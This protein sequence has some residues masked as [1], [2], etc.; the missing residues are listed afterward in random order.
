MAQRKIKMVALDLDGTL[1]SSD[2][3][4]GALSKEILTRL[5]KKGI[6]IT[7]STGRAFH[8]THHVAALLGFPVHIV[9]VDGAYI[10]PL[11]Y[12]DPIL[13]PFP[14]GLIREILELL[15]DDLP[16]V[17]LFTKD[18]IWCRNCQEVNEQIYGWGSQLFSSE[19]NFT[20]DLQI[21]QIVYINTA[22]EADALHQLLRKE[23]PSLPAEL[24]LSLEP[25]YHQIT[26]RP[27]GVNK[28]TGLET[29]AGLLGHKL[30][31]T[32]VFGDWLNDLPMLE[33]A[34]LAVTPANSVAEV[35][36]AADIIS[37]YTSDED[38]VGRELERLLAE[39]RII[40]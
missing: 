13:K 27:P 34:G 16:Y 29:L 21:L 26:I 33:K 6:H 40:A 25:G 35:K 15:K 17:Y 4:L 32:V 7:L 3:T 5:Y 19:L 10:L 28:G 2:K 36:A 31:E 38:F 22:A 14:T 18:Q 1:L 8:H 12:K 24:S 30:E 11:G 20:A 9:C 23:M 37:A 39:K